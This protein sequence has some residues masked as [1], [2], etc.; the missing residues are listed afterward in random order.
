[1]INRSFKRQIE[2]RLAESTSLIQVIVGPRQVGKTTAIKQLL[3]SHGLYFTADSPVPFGPEEI[4]MLW[5]QAMQMAVPLLAIDEIQKI[6]GWSETIKKLWDTK[7]KPIR[8][9]LSGS[10]ALSIEKNLKESLAGR[11][12]LIRVEHWN[13]SEAK[14]AFDID[15]ETFLEFGCYPGSIPLLKD[16]ERWAQYIRDSIVEP[17]IGRDI[18]QLHPVENPALLRQ[19]FSICIGHPAQIISLNK[20]QGQLQ[21]RGALSTLQNYL[22]LLGFGFLVTGIQKYTANALRTRQSPPKLIVHDNAL[23]RAFER[24][25]QARPESDRLGFYLENAIGARFIEAG[26]DTFYWKDRNLE[27]DFVVHGPA[28]EKWAIEVKLSPPSEYELRGLMN[29]CRQHSDFNPIIICP[30]PVAIRDVQYI[31]VERILSL[32]RHDRF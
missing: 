1:M 22:E 26:W 5:R 28:G 24:P 11:Y 27:V 14:R 31:S 19:V 13:F 30:K 8:L 2:S 29:F 4:E 9:L 12:E 7:T 15:F 20:L 3:K 17:A 21:D 23:I 32:N 18:L 25:V 16:K 6:S 10:A